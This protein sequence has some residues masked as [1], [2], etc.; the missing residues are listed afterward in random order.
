VGH[1]LWTASR[2]TLA[3]SEEAGNK[4]IVDLLKSSVGELEQVQ[5]SNRR[6]EL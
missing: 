3:T 5:T 1:P 6:E 4:E 2:D